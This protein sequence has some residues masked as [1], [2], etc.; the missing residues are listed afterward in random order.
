MS[1]VTIELFSPSVGS[2][3]RLEPFLFLNVGCNALDV[4]VTIGG[5][6]VHNLHH[7]VCLIEEDISTGEVFTNGEF[8]GLKSAVNAGK[9]RLELIE[10]SFAGLLSGTLSSVG[11]AETAELNVSLSP[12]SDELVDLSLLIYI[13]SEELRLV[14]AEDMSED[15]V[16]L[17]DLNIPINEEW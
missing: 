11:V 17:G 14:L 2:A 8:A 15:G 16:V 13:S 6:L 12:E 5:G 1:S 7:P 4:G 9:L 10:G 3:V